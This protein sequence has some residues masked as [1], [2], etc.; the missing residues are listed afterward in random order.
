[1]PGR[2]PTNRRGD[3]PRRFGGVLVLPNA[4]YFPACLSEK[5]VR[6]PVA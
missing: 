3:A 5:A 2:S 6:V 1:M 4:N